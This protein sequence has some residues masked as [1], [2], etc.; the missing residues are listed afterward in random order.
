MEW[1]WNKYTRTHLKLRL[2]L[3]TELR[4]FCLHVSMIAIFCGIAYNNLITQSYHQNQ[5]LKRTVLPQEEV[6]LLYQLKHIIKY[7]P[8]QSLFHD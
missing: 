6:S 3:Y 7:K 4:N 1:K 5:N 2:K 8:T